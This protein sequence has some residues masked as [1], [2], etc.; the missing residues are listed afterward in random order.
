MSLGL[1]PRTRARPHGVH[2]LGGPEVRPMLV[3]QPG[4][5]DAAGGTRA[6]LNPHAVATSLA[7]S[8]PIVRVP[9]LGWGSDPPN[10]P[11]S[12]PGSC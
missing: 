2:T 11:E 7:L 10:C 1:E 9:L 8:D 5:L 6:A 4:C 3:G 12:Y